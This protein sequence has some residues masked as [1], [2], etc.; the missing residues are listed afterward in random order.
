MIK[1]FSRRVL[2]IYSD[3]FCIAY[4]FERYPTFL[5]GKKCF[6]SVKIETSDSLV[7][8]NILVS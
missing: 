7:F 6:A 1:W 5:S 4:Y 2:I 3:R 8:T